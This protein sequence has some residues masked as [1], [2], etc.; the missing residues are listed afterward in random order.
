MVSVV[1]AMKNREKYI[2][3]AIMSVLN[4]TFQ[5]FEIVVLDDASSDNSCKVVESIE[6]KRIKLIKF[7]KHQGI[8][9]IRNFG[10]KIAEGK[11][12]SIFD[13][14]DIMPDSRLEVQ[15]KYM[16]ENLDIGVCGGGLTLLNEPD[17]YYFRSG[18]SETINIEQMFHTMVFHGTAMIRKSVL[19]KYDLKYREE[20][21]YAE[22]WALWV[23]MINKVK[24]AN[25]DS[26]LLH[27]RVH[28]E[29]ITIQTRTDSKEMK[30]RQERMADIFRNALN[31][32]GFKLEENEIKLFI[33][34]NSELNEYGK[35][36]KYTDYIAM[37]KLIEKMKKQ[38][39]QLG[40][41]ESKFNK[42]AYEW[43]DHKAIQYGILK[44]K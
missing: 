26:N 41:N 13:S 8:A 36:P 44:K 6:D 2:E 34:Y 17:F 27:Y 38:T 1:I 9:K 19:I 28:D 23:D 20:L 14:D 11:Y 5:D 42:I 25:I 43:I 33:F 22:D 31:N 18:D 16:E 10:N 40:I 12:I 32:H 24:M 3:E 29:G 39:N 35:I 30:N 37:Q 21:P 4:Q 7:Q 15:Y